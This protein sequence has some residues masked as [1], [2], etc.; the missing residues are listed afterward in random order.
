MR[1]DRKQ[2]ERLGRL[3]EGLAVLVLRLKGF[4]ILARRFSIGRGAGAGEV[5]LIARRGHQLAFIE[6]KAR[7]DL[8]SA[9]S[10]IT[11]RQRTR[12]ARGAEAFLKSRPDLA[13][14]DMRFD[15]MLIVRGRW[16]RHLVNAWRVGD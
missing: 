16:P 12:I 7:P 8:A 13:G 3:A 15:A 5:D 10:A 1:V 14:L 4:R 2:S 9:V 6:V 11:P